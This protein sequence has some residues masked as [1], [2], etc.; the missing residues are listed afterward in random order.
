MLGVDGDLT[1]KKVAKKWLKCYYI[2]VKIRKLVR[3]YND[4]NFIRYSGGV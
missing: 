4:Y 2:K 3:R 1:G